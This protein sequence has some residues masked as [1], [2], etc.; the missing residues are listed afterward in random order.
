M[1]QKNPAE[2]QLPGVCSLHSGLDVKIDFLT[3]GMAEIRAD[4]KAIA[5]SLATEDGEKKGSGKIG[6]A[7]AVSFGISTPLCALVWAIWTGK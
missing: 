6:V 3:T 4:V 2:E 1:A 5:K 7:L